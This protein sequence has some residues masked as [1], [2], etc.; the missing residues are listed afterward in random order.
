MIN[1]RKIWLKRRVE[2]LP[3]CLNT[4][5]TKLAFSKNVDSLWFV[6]KIIYVGLYC[7]NLS[8]PNEK[9]QQIFAHFSQVLCFI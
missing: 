5:R 6:C 4:T 7:D 2:T 8:I 9:N 3:K 1:F